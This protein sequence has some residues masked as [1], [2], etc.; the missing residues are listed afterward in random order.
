[1]DGPPPRGDHQ[2]MDELAQLVALMPYATASA[3]PPRARQFTPPEEKS[4][5]NIGMELREVEFE[6]L[7]ASTQALEPEPQ[8]AREGSD[9]RAAQ[10]V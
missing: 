10:R 2:D 7:A 1:M 9:E 5:C 3:R 4:M 6:P 8:P